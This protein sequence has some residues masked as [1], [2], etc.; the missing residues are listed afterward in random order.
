MYIYVGLH[1]L[2]CL[3]KIGNNSDGTILFCTYNFNVF[4]AFR[5]ICVFANP[6]KTGSH[7]T[8]NQRTMPMINK[9]LK[10]ILL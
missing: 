2:K 6:S 5:S 3:T 4:S 7:K 8:N 9:N 1:Y 10:T